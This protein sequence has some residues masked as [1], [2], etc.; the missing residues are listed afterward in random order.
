MR[1]QTRTSPGIGTEGSEKWESLPL[2]FFGNEGSSSHESGPNFPRT[3]SGTE[4]P[5]PWFHDHHSGNGCVS[6]TSVC[7]SRRTTESAWR[8]VCLGAT[9]PKSGANRTLRKRKEEAV[10]F[11]LEAHNLENQFIP[12]KTSEASAGSEH[13]GFNASLELVNRRAEWQSNK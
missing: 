5:R 4:R 7:V 3:L 6:D 12:T 2:Q 9:D 13:R 11:T 1:S 10:C 8:R